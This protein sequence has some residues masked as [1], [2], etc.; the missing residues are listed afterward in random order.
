MS[1]LY[2][3]RRLPIVRSVKCYCY[4]TAVGVALCL[5]R[6]RWLVLVFPITTGPDKDLSFH[7]S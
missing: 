2:I 3:V 5:A 4:D 1:L 7:Q 6:P